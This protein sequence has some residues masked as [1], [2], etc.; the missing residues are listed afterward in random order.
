MFLTSTGTRRLALALIVA[1]GALFA[2]VTVAYAELTPWKDYVISDAVWY[3]TTIKVEPNMDDV[4]LEGLKSG[5]V[6]S[7]EAEKKLAHIEEYRIFASS[8]PSSGDFNLMLIVK[9]KST[10]M[11]A[12]SKDR[13]EAFMKEVGEVEAKRR[14]EHAQKTYPAIRKITGDYMM[15]EITLK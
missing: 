7:M 12:P 9:Y 13:Y 2:A 5:W 10:A 3:V 8:T 4:Y 1:G 15:R 11:L 6:R 14:D